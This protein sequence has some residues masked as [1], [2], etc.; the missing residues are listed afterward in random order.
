MKPYQYRI[1]KFQL[2]KK[3]FYLKYF[4]R[5]KLLFFL[6]ACFDTMLLPSFFLQMTF[7]ATRWRFIL[8]CC[9]RSPHRQG[10]WLV[11]TMVV[12]FLCSCQGHDKNSS[13]PKMKIVVAKLQQPTQQLYYAG[14]L[15]PLKMQSVLSPV[16]GR[17]TNV[18]FSYGQFV[19]E[20]QKLFII[21]STR[22]AE[23]YRKTI[24]EKCVCQ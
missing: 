13:P 20:G 4:E 8:S 15:A 23:Q 11:L 12:F 1:Q 2:N 19:K 6:L 7:S 24:A 21:S 22:L 3:C 18:Y 17:I 14:V 16:E 5:K 9:Q 10:G